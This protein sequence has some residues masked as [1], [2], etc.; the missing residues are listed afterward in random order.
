MNM[1]KIAVLILL[2]LSIIG[3]INADERGDFSVQFAN[4]GVGLNVSRQRIFTDLSMDFLNLYFEN[5]IKNIGFKISPFSIRSYSYNDNIEKN[6][7]NEFI[8]LNICIYW[9]ILGEKEIMF[10]PFLSLQYLSFCERSNHNLKFDLQNITANAGLKL[11][12]KHSIFRSLGNNLGLETEFGY[13]YNY[14]NGHSFFIS[15]KAD[16][17]V[18]FFIIG[19]IFQILYTTDTTD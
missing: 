4:Y 14:Y 1:K 8:F 9:N 7:S 6:I 12:M 15:T 10:G 3:S 13:K 11:M 17:T 19:K 2:T 18:T 5:Y 16:L